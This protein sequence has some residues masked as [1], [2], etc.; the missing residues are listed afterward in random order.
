MFAVGFGDDDE[1]NDKKTEAKLTRTAN[2]MVD[3]ILRGTGVKGAVFATIKNTLLEIY[4]QYNKKSPEY[5]DVVFEATTLSPPI[6]SKLKKLRSAAR[7][8][9]WNKKE[10]AAKG[11]SLDNPA[12]LAYAQILSA[13]ANIP[14][15]R[16][17]KKV[18]NLVDATNSEA[19]LLQSIALIG[20]WSAW[21]INLDKPD[22]QKEPE[23]VPFPSKQKNIRQ[24]SNNKKT[25]KQ[26]KVKQ[27]N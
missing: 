18:T 14:L 15:D 2:G 9:Q 6:S 25:V 5:V 20:G 1:D 24:K 8:F 3:S 21:E 4:E 16:A 13:T 26:K 19:E 11:L 23:T 7:S 12:L 22:W 10:I 17:I 27:K